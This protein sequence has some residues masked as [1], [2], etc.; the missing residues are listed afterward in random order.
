MRDAAFSATSL[1]RLGS[2]DEAFS[3]LDWVLRVLDQRVE[4]DRFSPVY[5]VAGH[6]LP[7]E[8][9]IAELPGYGSSRPVRI[10]NAAGD[11]FQSDIFGPILDLMAVL[12]TSGQNLSA[13]HWR[14]TEAS[15]LAVSRRWNEPDHG[16]WQTRTGPRHHVYTK[17]MC[18]VA[19]DRAI[20]IAKGFVDQPP[21][22]WFD[23]RNE[24]AEDVL[25][26][27][28][29]PSID[30]FSASYDNEDLDASVLAI[31]LYG[32]IPTEDPR[33]IS[34][35]TTIAKRLR[36]GPTV[37]RY[38]ADDGLPGKEGGI[39]MMTAWLVK[40][41]GLTGSADKARE[42]FSQLCELTG[43]TGL[44]SDQYDP[45]NERSLGNV[46]QAISHAGLIDGAV[47]LSQ[48]D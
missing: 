17:V 26:K 36:N 4:P 19:V 6:H 5:N 39:H 16:I 30:S 10:G 9:E 13:E 11:Q 44:L 28:W 25:E 33:Y 20:E 46:P 18:W 8:A 35:V 45:S 48:L 32:L 1:A 47:F 23:L 31:G 42:L 2:Y 24:I 40:A 43:A 27:G 22:A 3:Y 12:V 15:V 34:T 41:L 29:K 37:Y 21:Q 38:L 14:L 7:P